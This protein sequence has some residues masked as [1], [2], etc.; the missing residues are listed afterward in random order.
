MQSVS[1]DTR[2]AKHL[3]LA[4]TAET[5][6]TTTCP[7]IL[8]PRHSA[9]PRLTVLR[10]S[11]SRWAQGPITLTSQDS[12][13]RYLPVRGAAPPCATGPVATVMSP[14]HPSTATSNLTGNVSFWQLS[15]HSDRHD[16]ITFFFLT[17]H[18]QGLHCW[19]CAPREWLSLTLLSEIVFS[20]QSQHL[21][22]WRTMAS[23]M[24][25]HLRVRSPC[26]GHGPCECL[27]LSRQVTQGHWNSLC[28][29]HMSKSFN[30]STPLKAS[31]FVISLTQL[32]EYRKLACKN[33]TSL[34]H[35][36]ATT[37]R[38][39]QMVLNSCNNFGFTSK[40]LRST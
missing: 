27:I 20:Q 31:F 6:M 33:S 8:A 24:S 11:T 28:K 3:W 4:Q 5:R 18:L 16:S 17:G 37:A 26:H 2:E 9:L 19:L 30:N 29:Y 23:L 38:G 40:N 21:W 34:K 7:W 32:V 35:R 22:I 1:V 36:L 14:R 39:F 13:Q 10:I 25:C 12:L 15:S